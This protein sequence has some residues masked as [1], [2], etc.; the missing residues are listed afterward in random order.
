M[1]N[2]KEILKEA[3]VLWKI[4]KF[5]NR[6]FYNSREFYESVTIDGNL[7]LNEGINSAVLT[8]LCGGTEDPFDNSHAYIGV[9]DSMTAA[10]AT[11]TGLQ[12]VTNKLYVGMD[13]GYPTYGTSQLAKWQATFTEAQTNFAWN[14]F[15]VANGSS[16]SAVN[17]N[18]K[19]S[20]QGT[21]SVGQLWEV[22]V[23]ITLA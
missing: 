19:V 11:Q 5:H 2:L 18:R 17:L 23:T 1:S 10:A 8:L 6:D 14:E 20:A 7:M 9:G 15:T 4:K 16:D 22:G 3:N 21:K 12:A 13:T